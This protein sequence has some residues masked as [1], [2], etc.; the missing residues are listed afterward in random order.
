M[1]NFDPNYP[2]RSQYCAWHDS[3]CMCQI[4]ALLEHNLTYDT[5]F[6]TNLD[7]ELINV[8][9]VDWSNFQNKSLA[10]KRICGEMFCISE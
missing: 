6:Y 8:V 10:G 4:V 5:H 9:S 7:R 1:S 3:G 2:I